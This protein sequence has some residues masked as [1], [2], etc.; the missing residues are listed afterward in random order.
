[1]ELRRIQHLID[2]GTNPGN[3]LY[4]SFDVT[5]AEIEDVL[6]TYEQEKLNTTSAITPQK[7]TS[8]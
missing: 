8:S 3:I 7:L 1:M 5:K 6:R 2:K 4:F